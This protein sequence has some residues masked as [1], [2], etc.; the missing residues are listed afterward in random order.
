MEIAYY[1]NEGYLGYS[2]SDLNYFLSIPKDVQN[3]VLPYLNL[4]GFYSLYLLDKIKNGGLL[5]YAFKKFLSNS[6]PFTNSNSNPNS[7][8]NSNSNSN[9]NSNN[10]EFIIKQY[11]SLPD[12]NQRLIYAFDNDLEI[13]LKSLLSKGVNYLLLLSKNPY[14]YDRLINADSEV[15]VNPPSLKLSTSRLNQNR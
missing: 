5:D 11:L 8:P 9:S 14:N 13:A 1:L 7:N 4:K 12:D 6:L 10:L 3:A 2:E 15:F